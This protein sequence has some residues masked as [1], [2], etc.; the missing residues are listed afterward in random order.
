MKRAVTSA[1]IPKA[2]EH[3]NYKKLIIRQQTPMRKI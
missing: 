1:V 3:V 2:S